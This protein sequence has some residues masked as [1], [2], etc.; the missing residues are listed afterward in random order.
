MTAQQS[1]AIRPYRVEITQAD[2]DELRDR[3]DR[4][5][6]TSVIDGADD[7]YGTALA[8]SG[9][10]FFGIRR[11]AER[12][13]ANIVR[14]NVYETPGHYTAH[15]APEVLVRDVVEFFGGLG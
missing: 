15:Q 7:A 2:L 13:H 6:W 1:T 4:T 5:R 9:G 3:L 12:D 10:D 8:G 14:W 11:F